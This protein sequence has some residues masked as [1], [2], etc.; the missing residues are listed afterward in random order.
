MVLGVLI[1]PPPR[2]QRIHMITPHESHLVFPLSLPLDVEMALVVPTP[3]LAI[4][5]NDVV[6]ALRVEMAKTKSYHKRE[7]ELVHLEHANE[8]QGLRAQLRRH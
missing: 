5:D 2:Q 6:E 1:E 4:A 8:V 3:P 7:L